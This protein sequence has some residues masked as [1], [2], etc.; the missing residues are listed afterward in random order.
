MIIVGTK[1]VRR[2]FK[3]TLMYIIKVMYQNS[4]PAARIL[5]PDFHELKTVLNSFTFH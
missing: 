4:P 3:E 5:F 2:G 1:A